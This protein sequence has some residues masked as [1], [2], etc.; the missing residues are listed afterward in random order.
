[1]RKIE[2]TVKRGYVDE[3]VGGVDQCVCGGLISGRGCEMYVDII[4]NDDNIV[5]F[6]GVVVVNVV[7]AIDGLFRCLLH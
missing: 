2:G 7:V 4:V 3:F 6:F 5:S 1:M